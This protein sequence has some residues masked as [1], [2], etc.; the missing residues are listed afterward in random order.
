MSVELETVSPGPGRDFI[1]YGRNAPHVAL[2]GDAKV[3]VNL[4]LV[5]EG[6]SQYSWLDNHASFL[7]R[8]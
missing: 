7:P 8:G 1:G 4:A 3:A 2:P 6:G 5:Y